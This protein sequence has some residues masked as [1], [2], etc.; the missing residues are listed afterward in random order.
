MGDCARCGWLA[1]LPVCLRSAARRRGCNLKAT[2]LTSESRG[3]G[4]LPA[5][6][7][8]DCCWRWRPAGG[9]ACELTGPHGAARPTRAAGVSH[10]HGTISRRHG[11]VVIRSCTVLYTLTVGRD[12]KELA[13]PSPAPGGG[14]RASARPEF[15]ERGLHGNFK[16]QLHRC[17]RRLN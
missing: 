2:A 4:G 12:C 6:W 7:H 16:F 17:P 3:S 1:R 10:W 13:S 15:R 5:R 8:G 11:D 9:A 14:A